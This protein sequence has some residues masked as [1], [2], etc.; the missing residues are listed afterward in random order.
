[1]TT[2]I[3][4]IDDSDRIRKQ[5]IHTLMHFGV[6]CT[7][8]AW[9]VWIRHPRAPVVASLAL[10]ASAVMTVQSVYWS[11]LPGDAAPGQQLPRAAAAIAHAA[12][13]MTYLL[14]SRRVRAAFD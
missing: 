2:S 12:G 6:C 5:L 8:R 1:M 9:G 10:A 7:F 4:I 3:L 14:R 13:W 11:Y